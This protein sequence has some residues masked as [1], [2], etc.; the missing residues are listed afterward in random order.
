MKNIILTFSL[1]LTSQLL[2]A[3]G[4]NGHRVVAQICYDNLTIEARQEIDNLL[5]DDYLTQVA[6]WPDFIKS[7]KNWDFAKPWHY[8]TVHPNQTVSQVIA[9]GK[10]NPKIENAIEAIELMKA[11]LKGDD[12]ATKQFQELMEENAV[13]PLSGSIKATALAFLIHIVGDIHQPMHC[14][15]NNDHGGNKISVLFFNEKSNIHAV[16]DSGIV[17]KEELSYTEFSAF[18]VKHTA[19]KKASWE[20]ASLTTW[21]E[22]SIEQRELIYNTIYDNTDRTTGLPNLSYSYQHDFLPVVED[23][24]GAAGYR[25]AVLL[26]ACF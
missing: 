8:V 22:E 21:V 13:Q 15:K 5:G 25:A 12:I 2:F 26:N 17:E 1:L 11:I 10:E 16:W 9:K 19:S 20:T 7:E 4:Q 3:W 6:N 18:T 14:G 23:R 24:L